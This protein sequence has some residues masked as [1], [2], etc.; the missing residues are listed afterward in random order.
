M[1]KKKTAKFKMSTFARI[2]KY[3]EHYLS[4][5]IISLILTLFSVALTL[6]I[7]ILVGDA[8]DLAVGYKNVDHGGILSILTKVAVAIVLTALFQWF[9]NVINNKITYRIVNRIRH[10]AFVKIQ[11]FPVSYIDSHKVGDVV[12]RVINDTDQFSDGLLMG[13]TQFFNGIF[14]I[15]GTLIFMLL[16][17]P[18]IALIVVVLTPASLFVAAFIAKRTFS[19][20][21][22]QSQIKGEQTSLIDESITQHKTV[23]AFSREE[24]TVEKFNE[25]N[26]RLSK[27]SL[28]AIFFSS[29]TN[30]STRF[31]NSII[32]AIVALVGALSFM[33]AGGIAITFG[34]LSSFLAYA[35][36]Y[37]KPF[38]E[39]SGVVTEL[40]NA[41]ACAERVFEVIDEPAQAP[42][43]DMPVEVKNVLG[44]VE[45][46][47]VS[48][49]YTPE[50]KLIENFNFAA[51]PGQR[52]AIVGPTGCGKTTLI[53][54]LM[55]YY[56][57]NEGRILVDGVD[58]REMRR[59]DLRDMFG[60]VLQDTWIAPGTVR[61]NIAFGK[62]DATDEE[63]VSAA[64]AVHAHSF[65][66]KLPNGYDTVIDENVSSLSGG[67]KQLLCIAR[68]ML[69]LPEIL[70]LDEATSSIDTRTEMKI[71]KAFAKMMNGRT[72]F[73]VAHRLSTVKEADVILVMKD[74]NVIE[75]GNH[76]SLLAQGGFYTELFTSQ[77]PHIKK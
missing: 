42:E 39:R 17:S 18:P 50:Q 19:M 59:A 74:G 31:V 32:Y 40:Q 48:F 16:L 52:V 57:V 54:L 5:F 36:Q 47:N 30:P 37:T 60:M 3:L 72:S 9:I 13:L 15:I 66:R 35:N 55:R 25:I 4:L 73:I 14:T 49:S 10:E 7:P 26:D 64:K 67:Q 6:Y 38:N 53:N 22:L 43:T 23:V 28:R 27:A 46:E 62:P 24:K 45:F 51:S 2:T 75:K 63:I 44:K 71:Q 69:T 8:I 20:F 21:K 12:S 77:F 11:K 29:I 41:L 65:I 33:K 61:D 76:A 34:G 1:A 70:I 68:V 58:I 56:D